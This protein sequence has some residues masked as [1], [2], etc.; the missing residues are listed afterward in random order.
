MVAGGGFRRERRITGV[1][2]MLLSLL[3]AIWHPGDRSTFWQGVE[4]RL[5]DA[6]FL[7]RGP[8]APPE[9][10]AIIA[11]DDAAMSQLETFPPPRSALAEVLSVATDAGVTAVALDFLLIGSRAGDKDLAK[12][13]AGIN[14]VLGVA[15]APA[16]A[17]LQDLKGGGFAVVIAPEMDNPLPALGPAEALRGV[18]TLGHV[19]LRHDSDGAARRLG[20]AQYLATEDG[21]AWYPSLALAAMKASDAK[22]DLQLR[23]SQTSGRLSVGETGIALDG[24]G[25]IPLNFYGPAGTIPTY[26]FAELGDADLQGKVLFVGATATG[27]GD[28]HATSYD[29]TFPGVELHATLAA[30]VIE[31]RFLRRGAFTWV[32]DVALALTASTFG[33]FAAKV[34]RPWLGALATA[35]VSIALAIVLQAT[36]VAGWWL[37]GVTAIFSLLLG[38][39]AGAGLR[40]VQHRRRAANLALYQSPLLV[41]RLADATDPH[42][43]ALARPA[44]VLFVDVANFTAHSERLGPA[45]TADFLRLFH[46][47][48]EQS[49]EPL[50]GIIAHFAGD[51]AMVVFGLPEPGPDDTIRALRFIEALYATVG[52]SSDWP[53]LGLR[54]GGHA[55]PVQT[56]VIGGKRHKQLAVSGD[57]VNTAS[58]LQD[59]AKSQSAAIALSSALLNSNPETLDR[60]EKMGLRPAGQHT[61]RGRIEP[62]EIWT[63]PPPVAVQ[64]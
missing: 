21:N 2:V 40:L 18:A 62:I 17:A 51:G 37:D 4:G 29:A 31:Q 63:G 33:F 59:F 23:L 1:I 27:F 11:F 12:A 45:G 60:A 9:G 19:N 61:L 44:V 14:A 10:V 52:T 58:R 38:A 55:G 26:S 54:V 5:L 28:R 42:F 6:R 7:W 13:L 36:F 39:S 49:L 16:E 47:L 53:G 22:L 34:D 57:V 30:N 48:V 64:F 43:D 3:I 25:A 50:N 32:W 56:S 41:E 24:Q 8:L 46:G 15:E 35:T 20:A